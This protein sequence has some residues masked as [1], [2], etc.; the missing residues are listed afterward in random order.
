MQC[1]LLTPSKMAK[2]KYT[3]T[4]TYHSRFCGRRL[5]IECTKESHFWREG[6]EWRDGLPTE[7]VVITI[8]SAAYYIVYTVF[9][10]RAL[11]GC[12]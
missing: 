5:A 4:S 10:K 3:K 7:H 11:I 1:G 8:Q 9:M 6:T 12:C 2:V